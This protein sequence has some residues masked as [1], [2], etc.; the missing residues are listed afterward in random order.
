MAKFIGG[1]VVF[2]VRGEYLIMASSHREAADIYCRERRLSYI[3]TEWMGA[4]LLRVYHSPD[5]W[6]LV[7]TANLADIEAA[8]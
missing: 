5:N 7:Q 3:A 1:T 2:L 8:A 6:V 4:D